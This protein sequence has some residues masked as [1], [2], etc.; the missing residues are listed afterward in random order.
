MATVPIIAHPSS[1]N[2]T[3]RNVTTPED[4]S[5]F[6][7]VM[8]PR[9]QMARHLFQKVEQIFEQVWPLGNQSGYITVNGCDELGMEGTQ[10][11]TGT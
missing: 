9:N 1:P 2:A 6:F 10:E 3:G 7:E 11:T 8:Q 4:L 5:M